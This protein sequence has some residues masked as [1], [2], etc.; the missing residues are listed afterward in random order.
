MKK[1]LILCLLFL[2]SYLLPLT[3]AFSKPVESLRG[4]GRYAND[5]G[6]ETLNISSYPKVYQEGYRLTVQ[7]C[8]KCH[9]ASRVFN[10]EL[11]EMEPEEL[12]ALKKAQPDW[13]KH[14]AIRRMDKKFWE[15]HVY[16]MTMKPK[17]HPWTMKEA[18]KIKQFLIYDSQQRKL[19][20]RAKEWEAHRRRL[21][22]AFKKQFPELYQDRYAGKE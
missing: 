15:R 12:A 17:A 6:P 20:S 10:S 9:A 19:G 11:I 4:G 3:T 18:E 7:H 16:R 14:P 2:T 21:L 22:S 8:S 5:F 1:I 13:F